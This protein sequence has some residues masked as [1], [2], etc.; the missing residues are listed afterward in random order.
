MQ[1]LVIDAF[2]DWD[3]Q[4][5]I[6]LASTNRSSTF[7]VNIAFLFALQYAFLNYRYADEGA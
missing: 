6:C 4:Y 2:V 5:V 3:H 1:L 7:A